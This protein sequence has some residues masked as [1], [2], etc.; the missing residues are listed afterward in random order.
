MSTMDIQQIRDELCHKLRN[1]D[2]LTIGVRGVATK[3]DNFTATAG[4][5]AFT[6]TG[7]GVRNIRSLT[8]N[9]VSKS[10]LQDYTVNWTTGVVT[11]GTG[12]SLN[13]PVAIQYDYGTSDK[14]YPDMPRDDLTLVSYPRVGIEMTNISTMPIGLGG[15]TH[16]SD[17]V[18]TIICWV[19]VNKD[20]AIASGYGG[21][22]DLSGLMKNI[23]DAIRTNA[24]LFYTFQ[25]ITPAGTGPLI[26]GQNNKVMQESVDYKIKF[27]IE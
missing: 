25:Y 4:Q 24:K 16:Q 22:S 20:S 18:I 2:I 9:S 27:K 11:L 15:M 7:A 10:Y 14:I 26:R 21:L 1:S 13:D 8:V 5:V 19:P 12:A 3:T 17:I 23:R 6:L